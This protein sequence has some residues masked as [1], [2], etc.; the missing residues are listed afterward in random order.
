MPDS[1]RRLGFDISRADEPKYLQNAVE[2][3]LKAALGE[4][5]LAVQIHAHTRQIVVQWGHSPNANG[6]DMISFDPVTKTI[7]LWD[8]KTS[9]AAKS[10][11]YHVDPRK[12]DRWVRD[13]GSK[14]DFSGILGDNANAFKDALVSDRVRVVPAQFGNVKNPFIIGDWQ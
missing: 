9:A 6:P 14:T 12:L 13:Y 11:N 2:R 7:Y 3:D 5:A 1:S 10:T 8:S 4:E